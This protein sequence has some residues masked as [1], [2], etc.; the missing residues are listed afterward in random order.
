M[1]R[2]SL[3]SSCDALDFDHAL[4]LALTHFADLSLICLNSRSR[5]LP[6][7]RRQQSVVHVSFQDARPDQL[8]H[9]RLSWFATRRRSFTAFHGRSHRRSFCSVFCRWFAAVGR[10]P[11]S[12]ACLSGSFRP[13]C[14]TVDPSASRLRDASVVHRRAVGSPGVFVSRTPPS[15]VLHRRSLAAVPRASP[16]AFH[17]MR[18]FCNK[19]YIK[20]VDKYNTTVLLEL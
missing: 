14:A 8:R 7:G 2:S 1:R 16:V 17:S 6:G 20:R 18:G 10:P 15:V 4:C 13:R 9:I 19:K 5:A 11:P 3:P 12:V